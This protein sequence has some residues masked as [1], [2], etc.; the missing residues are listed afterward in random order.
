ML[1]KKSKKG[2]ADDFLLV[3]AEIVIGCLLGMSIIAYANTL[4]DS[5]IG[6]SLYVSRDVSATLKTA[7]YLPSSFNIKYTPS[8]EL[9]D[10]CLEF[11]DL[12]VKTQICKNEYNLVGDFAKTSYTIPNSIQLTTPTDEIRLTEYGFTKK[13]N[14]LTINEQT[15]LET[16]DSSET[17]SLINIQNKKIVNYDSVE[18]FLL[19]DVVDSFTKTLN[20]Q[21]KYA[22]TSMDEIPLLVYFDFSETDQIQVYYSTNSPY[23]K[24]FAD[25]I[26][27]DLTKLL[28]NLNNNQITISR[29]IKPVEKSMIYGENKIV[30][31]L[32]NSFKT[33]SSR[34]PNALL[35][36]IS[37][38]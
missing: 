8:Y 5:T 29:E 2:I 10:K 21:I 25:E 28:N 31:L 11:K 19:F 32:P 16:L 1:F 17:L 4:T 33:D 36:S 23:L 27:S 14:E 37:L 15:N 22:G 30:I 20:E 3:I 6:T 18:Y 34:L 38:T 26:N 35:D 24:Y 12:T 9:T 13:D 7:S